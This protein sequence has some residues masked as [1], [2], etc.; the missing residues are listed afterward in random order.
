MRGLALLYLHLV[1]CALWLLAMVIYGRMSYRRFFTAEP[2]EDAR[3]ALV[4]VE[5]SRLGFRFASTTGF[6]AMIAIGIMVYQI[7]GRG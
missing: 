2:G 5:Q 1:F 4:R 7:I 6:V 3:G